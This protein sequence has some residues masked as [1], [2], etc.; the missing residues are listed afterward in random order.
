MQAA[1]KPKLEAS[2]DRPCSD[3]EIDLPDMG[4][5]ERRSTDR[6][7]APSKCGAG[8]API[9]GGNADPSCTSFGSSSRFCSL[10]EQR[11]RERFAKN[12]SGSKDDE[13]LTGR[14]KGWTSSTRFALSTGDAFPRQ[15]I[16]RSECRLS[17]QSR[18]RNRQLQAGVQRCGSSRPTEPHHRMLPKSTWIGVLRPFVRPLP[19]WLMNSILQLRRAHRSAPEPLAA[20]DRRG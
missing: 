18:R 9:L 15:S 7:P 2:A 3:V 16:G 17:S 10:I 8:T 6:A 12:A 14:F 11:R 4:G 5:G 19:A 20:S 13:S 1:P